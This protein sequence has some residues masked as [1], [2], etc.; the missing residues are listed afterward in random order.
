MGARYKQHDGVIP[1]KEVAINNF[2]SL[3]LF[4]EKFIVHSLSASHKWGIPEINNN[5]AH[6]IL[7]P[8]ELQ[9]RSCVMLSTINTR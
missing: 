5:Y 4:V 3:H 6:V 1:K 9:P 2:N 7:G 8:M